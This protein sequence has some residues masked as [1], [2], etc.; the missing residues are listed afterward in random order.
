MFLETVPVKC[1]TITMFTRF[2]LNVQDIQTWNIKI[3]WIFLVQVP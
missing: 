2:L 3:I 1:V